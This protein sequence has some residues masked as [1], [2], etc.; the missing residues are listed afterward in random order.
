MLCDCPTVQTSGQEAEVME[1]RLPKQLPV[2]DWNAYVDAPGAIATGSRH[3]P[4]WPRSQTTLEVSFQYFLLGV[5]LSQQVWIKYAVLNLKE[6]LIC[7]YEVL[8]QESTKATIYV[9]EKWNYK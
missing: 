5:G 2:P 4:L 6:V 9:Q 8:T 1:G 3:W 7:V